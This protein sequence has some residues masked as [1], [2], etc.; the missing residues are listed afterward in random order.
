MRKEYLIDYHARDIRRQLSQV[1]V[2]D[3]VVG[4]MDVTIRFV[5]EILATD[6]SASNDVCVELVRDDDKMELIFLC[7]TTSSHHLVNDV[8]LENNIRQFF[9]NYYKISHECSNGES[10][11]VFRFT[12]LPDKEM[13]EKYLKALDKKNIYYNE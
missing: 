4:I 2:N 3:R 10:K 13:T 1:V 9:E 11:L 7:G 8:N 6:K 5:T 12:L